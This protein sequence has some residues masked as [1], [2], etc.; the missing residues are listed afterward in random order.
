MSTPAK[1]IAIGTTLHFQRIALEGSYVQGTVTVTGARRDGLASRNY[2]E[3]W[4][5]WHGRAQITPDGPDA[6]VQATGPTDGR[7]EYW[8]VKGWLE[9]GR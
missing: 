8:T 6:I 3:P 5:T 1:P 9:D 7:P 4:S 2:E